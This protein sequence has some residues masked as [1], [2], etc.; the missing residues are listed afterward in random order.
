MRPV[1][2]ARAEIFLVDDLALVQH[3]EAVGVG[4]RRHVAEAD[5]LAVQSGDGNLV[6]VALGARQLRDWTFAAPHIRRRPQFADMAERPSRARE[7]AARSVVEAHSPV[8]RRRKALHHA[9][10]DGIGLRRAR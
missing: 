5:L 2:V 7:F 8:G 6:E 4:Q 9:V 3:Q 1:R 10:G